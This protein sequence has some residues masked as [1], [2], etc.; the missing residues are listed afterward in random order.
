MLDRHACP[1]VGQCAACV[2]AWGDLAA[3]TGRVSRGLVDM[4][5]V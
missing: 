2:E 4:K 3:I 5:S 1:L